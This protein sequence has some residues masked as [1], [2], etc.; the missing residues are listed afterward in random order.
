MHEYTP[1]HGPALGDAGEGNGAFGRQVEVVCGA[2][3][4]VGHCFE[5]ARRVGTQLEVGDGE[6]VRWGAAEGGAVEGGYGARDAGGLRG[7]W[8]DGA[9]DCDVAGAM[10]ECQYCR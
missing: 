4:E 5:V 10:V 8:G 9:G 2:E 7:C 1:W 3:G 6:V